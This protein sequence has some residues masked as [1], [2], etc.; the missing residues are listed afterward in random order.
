MY[1]RLFGSPMIEGSVVL[2]YQGKLYGLFRRERLS[3]AIRTG[4]N[5][6]LRRG[7]LLVK[8]IIVPEGG[9]VVNVLFNMPE[10][11]FVADD[12]VVEGTLPGKTCKACLPDQFGCGGFIYSHQL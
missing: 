5:L 9:V 7:W 4:R 6:S 8:N 1:V 10:C 12:V 2:R 11:S 3:A